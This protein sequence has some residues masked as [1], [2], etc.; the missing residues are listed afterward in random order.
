MEI[1]T[2]LPKD[3]VQMMKP[4]L[5]SEWQDF[6]ESL[7]E[8]HIRGIR[9][10][11]ALIDES[12]QYSDED[13]CVKESLLA[14]HPPI[15]PL[16]GHLSTFLGSKIPWTQ[17]GYYIPLDSPL[18][19]SVYHEAGLYYIQEPSAMAVVEAL[20]PAKG[21]YILDLCAAP[22]GKCTEIGRR[23]QGQGVLVANEIHPNR[24]VILAENIER[25][26]IQAV[27]TQETAQH[28]AS[29][30]PLC[31]DGVLVDAPCSGEGMFRKDEKA[32]REWSGES[33]EICS[34]R[35]KEI[36]LSASQLICPGGRLVYSTCTFNPYENERVIDWLVE[37]LNFEVEE[38]PDWPGWSPGV[39]EWGSGKQYLQKTRRLWPHIGNGEGH[40]VA[41][42]RKPE[43]NASRLPQMADSSRKKN[44]LDKESRMWQ[45]FALSMFH[46]GIL[47]I[48][49]QIP[50][51]RQGLVFSSQLQQ[52]PKAKLKILRPGTQ[53]ATI[54]SHGVIPHHALAMSLSS[55]LMEH[56][57]SITEEE[58]IRYCEGNTLASNGERGFRH[59]ELGAFPLG[60]GKGLAD[61]VNNL[62]PKGLRKHNLVYLSK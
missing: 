28:L 19:K 61:R 34:A 24:V 31:F 4:L 27:V 20:Q 17:N 60:W 52:L 42:L 39:P 49:W 37:E 7:Q 45:E 40:F 53:L 47:P 25:L 57:L 8:K 38:L 16:P 36:L 13:G 12:P 26:G 48:H 58:A 56:S 46:S 1:I 35:Q 30:W 21:E 59:I 18:G 43:H 33:P 5:G 23:L 10:H 22:G 62:Y 9:L 14:L 50:I 55:G 3:F 51:V 29:A 44:T 41:R 6:N 54:E 2:L 32:R 15:P 11:R